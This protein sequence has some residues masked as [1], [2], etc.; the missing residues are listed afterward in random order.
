MGGVNDFSS[1]CIVLTAFVEATPIA[2]ARG[3]MR[4]AT[5]GHKVEQTVC[6]HSFSSGAKIVTQSQH[7]ISLGSGTPKRKRPASNSAQI[8]HL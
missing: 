6:H 2:K 8:H 4:S 1:F 5:E 7:A 3:D